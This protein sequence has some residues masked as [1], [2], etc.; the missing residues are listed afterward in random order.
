MKP[1]NKSSTISLTDRVVSVIAW[2]RQ[3][4][5]P[6]NRAGVERRGFLPFVTSNRSVRRIILQSY[7]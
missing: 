1:T 6:G 3:L 2:L 5:V 7:S 4:T